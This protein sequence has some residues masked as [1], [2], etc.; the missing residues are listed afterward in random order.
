MTCSDLLDFSGGTYEIIYVVRALM[1]CS[2]LLDF[3]GGTYEIIYV[4]RAIMT[5]CEPLVELQWGYLWE[6]LC[7]KSNNDLL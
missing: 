4:V 3:S 5:F 1:T 7:W 6:H 2:D